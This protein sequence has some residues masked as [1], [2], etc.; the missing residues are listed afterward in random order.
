MEVLASA[1]ESE[2]INPLYVDYKLFMAYE[3]A[4]QPQQRFCLSK[5]ADKGIDHLLYKGY[6]VIP[7]VG[8]PPYQETIYSGHWN[9]AGMVERLKSAIKQINENGNVLSGYT[10]RT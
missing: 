4:L 8:E 9:H 10:I 7:F 6:P 2:G 1:C 3:Q 5:L